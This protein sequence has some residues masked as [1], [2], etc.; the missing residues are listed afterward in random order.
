MYYVWIKSAGERFD[1]HSENHF[2]KATC[3]LQSYLL[4][5]R[6]VCQVSCSQRLLIWFDLDYGISLCSPLYYCILRY[7]C[8]VLWYL[9]RWLVFLTMT[10]FHACLKKWG[11]PFLVFDIFQIFSSIMHFVSSFIQD[12]F[13]P[14][15]DITQDGVKWLPD[16]IKFLKTLANHIWKFCC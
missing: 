12:L 16:V 1:A 4:E 9:E 14:F 2:L 6:T 5:L 3:I 15:E 8:L 7:D 10:N 11:H 13:I